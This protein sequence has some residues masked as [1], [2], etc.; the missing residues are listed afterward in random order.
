MPQKHH[1]KPD[2]QVKIAKRRIEF[3]FKEAKSVFKENSALSDRYAGL[4]RKIAM[5]YKIRLPPPL[6]KQVCKNCHRFLVAGVNCRV[7]IHKHR[8]IYYCMG[9]RHYIRQPVK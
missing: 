7:R 2:R 1:K 5:K 8:I 9:C 3:L 6:K 4:A